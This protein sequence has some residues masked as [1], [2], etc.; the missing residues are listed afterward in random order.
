MI[1]DGN[2]VENSM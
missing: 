1:F 2:S